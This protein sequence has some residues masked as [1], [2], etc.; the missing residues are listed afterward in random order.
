MAKVIA[1]MSGWVGWIFF[2]DLL[3]GLSLTLS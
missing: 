3:N 2:L 1:K